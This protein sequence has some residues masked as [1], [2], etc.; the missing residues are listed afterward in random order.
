MRSV[1]GSQSLLSLPLILVLFF[2]AVFAYFFP[3]G[4]LLCCVVCWSSGVG[5]AVFAAC[6]VMWAYRLFQHV[7][8]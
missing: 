6:A 7:V 4:F 5:Y 2:L 3:F 1:Y 8:P